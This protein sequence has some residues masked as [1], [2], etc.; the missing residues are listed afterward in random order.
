MINTE[1]KDAVPITIH[2]TKETFEYLN[3]L[4][5]VYG[6]NIEDIYYNRHYGKPIPGQIQVPGLR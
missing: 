1:V 6:M 2:V 5:L 3:S 4:A